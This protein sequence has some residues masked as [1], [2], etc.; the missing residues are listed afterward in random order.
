MSRPPQDREPNPAPESLAPVGAATL[1][2]ISRLALFVSAELGSIQNDVDRIKQLVAEGT[3]EIDSSF[4]ELSSQV[5]TQLDLV[6]SLKAED[7]EVESSALD[8]SVSKIQGSLAQ[9]I[10]AIQFEDLVR[11]LAQHLATRVL[12]L[13]SFSDSADQAQRRLAASAE[14]SC[15]EKVTEAFV[16]LLDEYEE[17]LHSMGQGAV[18]QDSLSEGEICLF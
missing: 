13:K 4:S 3:R 6:Q 17:L 8:E 12:L 10:Q 15:P 2:A 5:Q 11:Q 7:P 1:K 18:A 9:A 14:N 16:A